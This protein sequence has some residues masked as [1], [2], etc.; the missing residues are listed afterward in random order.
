MGFP[1]LCGDE[2]TSN[3][4]LVNKTDGTGTVLSIRI[5]KS[6]THYSSL[7]RLTVPRTRARFPVS[8]FMEF[9]KTKSSILVSK[10]QGGQTRKMSGENGMFCWCGQG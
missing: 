9:K 6:N 1:L 8:S 10:R 2:K 7:K 5:N 4:C 3:S